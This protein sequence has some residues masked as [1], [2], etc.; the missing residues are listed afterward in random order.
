M[1]VMLV[2]DGSF[3]IG[4]TTFNKLL[5]GALISLA[6]DLFNLGRDINIG[7]TLFSHAVNGNIAL[8][9]DFNAFKTGVENLQYPN[10]GTKTY[11]G[12]RSGIELLRQHGRTN[13]N[14]VSP[15]EDI[16]IVL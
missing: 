14:P 12:I 5:K 6:R 7:L 13:A 2:V 10:G 16:I 4:T 9:N 11:L 3:S 1:D 8:S 15:G